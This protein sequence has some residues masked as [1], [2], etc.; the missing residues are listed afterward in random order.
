MKKILIIMLLMG[1][2]TTPMHTVKIQ[3]TVR[4]TSEIVQTEDTTLSFK[5]QSAGLA[6]ILLLTMI[7]IVLALSAS[8]IHK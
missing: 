8:D 3:S 1:C 4:D 7:A 5:E 6:V 2:A